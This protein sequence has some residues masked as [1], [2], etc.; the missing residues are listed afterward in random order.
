[1]S[2]NTPSLFFVVSA[3]L[4]DGNGGFTPCP[5]VLTPEEA[6]RYL[7]IDKQ[8]ADPTKTLEYYQE[9]H[10]LKACTIGNNRRYLRKELDRFAEERT[11]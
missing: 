4:P 8:K 2:E 10:L 5:E 6:T 11:K 3:V 7:R 9:K 1:M